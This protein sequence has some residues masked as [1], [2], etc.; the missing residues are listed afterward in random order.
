MKYSELCD[1]YENISRTTKRLEKI[2]IL[3]NFIKKI[4]I[5]DKEVIYLLLGKVFPDY[6]ENE[7]GISNQ[8]IIKAIAKVSGE[9]EEKIVREWKKL[10]DLGEVAQ[11]LIL[12]K[13]QSSLFSSVLTV[14]KVMDNIREISTFEGKGTVGKKIDLISGLYSNAQPIEAK[15]ITRILLSD[16]RIGIQQ[17]T[18]RDALANLFENKKEVAEKIQSAYDLHPDMVLIFTH[19][20]KGIKELENI[21]L[22][23]GTP[24]RAMLA[25]KVSSI[26]EG[27]ETVGRP[28]A[29]EYKYDGFRIIASKGIE[30]GKEK[31]SLFTRSLENVTKQFP[32]VVE[33]LMKNVSGKSFILDCEVV[34]YS[35][36][37]NKYLPFQSISQRIKRKYDIE[38]IVKDFPV[39]VNVFDVLM[40]NDENLLNKTFNERTK[41]IRKVVKNV[42]YKIICAKQLITDSEEEAKEFFDEA[43]K[44][45]QEGVMIKN[46][47]GIYKPGSR[48]GYMVKLKPEHRDLDLVIVGAEYGTGKRAGWMSSFVLSCHDDEND[49]LLEVGRVGTGI[50]EKS[51]EGIS[52]DKLT[53]LLKPLIL[54]TNGKDVKVKPKIVVSVIYQ[55]IQ[56]SPTYSSGFALRFPRVIAFREDKPVS[57]INTLSDIK[58]EYQQKK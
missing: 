13:K 45:N 7:L 18:L 54:E 42:P 53:Q 49:E 56:K 34:G 9:S 40:Y 52:F 21:S 41:L 3:S 23:V 24:I 25:Q 51:E 36:K 4:L 2:D 12:K 10:G 28:A 35:S 5:E 43:L 58:K 6:T 31:I 8:T 37:F 22:N 29:F 48:V 32:D 20:K 27:F 15:Y 38:K 26:S 1:L 11:K 30:N 39:E 14:K 57:E 33:N 17:S 47:N 50:K 16:L 55:E 46:L 44:N 19:L